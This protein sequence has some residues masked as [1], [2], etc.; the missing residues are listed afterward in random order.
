MTKLTSFD[1]TVLLS[2]YAVMK[3]YNGYKRVKPKLITASRK[4]PLTRS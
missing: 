3:Q 2:S 1:S 4:N